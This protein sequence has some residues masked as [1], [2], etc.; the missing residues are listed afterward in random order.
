M[1]DRPGITPGRRRGFPVKGLRL[2]DRGRRV[3]DAASGTALTVAAAG[4][5]YSF[6]L[7]VTAVAGPEVI[8]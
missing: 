3:L 4:L 6:L 1:V 2:T 7:L 8:A 5:F